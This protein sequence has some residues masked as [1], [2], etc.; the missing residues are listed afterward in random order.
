MK[1]FVAGYRA[2]ILK[3]ALDDVLCKSLQYAQSGIQS[4]VYTVIDQKMLDLF[5]EDRIR[6]TL[7]AYIEKHFDTNSATSGLSKS[8]LPSSSFITQIVTFVRRE[9]DIAIQH[10]QYSVA[11]R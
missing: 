1:E 3:K 2:A 8:S 11:S 9:A 4:G 6:E 10:K 5:R 7:D